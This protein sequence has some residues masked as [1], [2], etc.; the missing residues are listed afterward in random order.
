MVHIKRINEMVDTLISFFK[1]NRNAD[2]TVDV[3]TTIIEDGGRTNAE[4][5][6]SVELKKD[7]LDWAEAVATVKSSESDAC[8]VGDSVEIEISEGD[9]IDD[10]A[11]TIMQE[12]DRTNGR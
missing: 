10:V 2:K 7:Y 12:F 3:V 11:T 4:V 1:D 5:V 8:K 6:W 9:D